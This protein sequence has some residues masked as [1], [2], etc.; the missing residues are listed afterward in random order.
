MIKL[1]CKVRPYN[2]RGRLFSVYCTLKCICMCIL[3]WWMP[4]PTHSN[5]QAVLDKEFKRDWSKVEE[6]N[7][8][9]KSGF[10]HWIVVESHS[11][12]CTKVP[13]PVSFLKPPASH[14]S[15]CRGAC[16][17]NVLKYY[18]HHIPNFVSKCTT[19]FLVAKMKRK[20]KCL[21]F[22]LHEMTVDLKFN[23]IYSDYAT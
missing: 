22:Y 19:F 15:F 6:T 14:Y 17:R 7:S 16:K 1:H 2:F 13:I 8:I 3:I 9:L 5:C 20:D 4:A 18:Q 12:P 11:E 10:L 21:C 23:D